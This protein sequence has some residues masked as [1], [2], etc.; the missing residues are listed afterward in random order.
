MGRVIHHARS[1][2]ASVE[3]QRDPPG[4]LLQHLARRGQPLAAFA[5]PTVGARLA[6]RRGLMQPRIEIEPTG[7]IAILRDGS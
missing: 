5:R 6:N 1:I 7:Q 3:V 4:A 2:P